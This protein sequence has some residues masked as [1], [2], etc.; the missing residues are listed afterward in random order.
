MVALGCGGGTA[1]DGKGSLAG[2]P[3]DCAWLASNNCWKTTVAAAASCV[4]DPSTRGTLSA[5]G[6]TCTYASG[7]TVDFATPVVLPIDSEP[8]WHFTVTTAGQQCLTYDADP[9]SDLALNVQGMSISEK[10]AGLS[11]QIT[12]PDGSQYAAP[13]AFDLLQCDDFFTDAPGNED[14]GTD[15]SVSLGLLDGTSM[16]LQVFD[17]ERAQ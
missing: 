8:P 6:T 16:P 14:S 12:C 15:T 1:D 13:N 17:C 10:S 3:L 2:A 4:P 5:D 7:T 11:L 9:N